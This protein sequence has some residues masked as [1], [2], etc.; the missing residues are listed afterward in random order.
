MMDAVVMAKGILAGTVVSQLLTLYAAPAFAESRTVPVIYAVVLLMLMTVS[1]ASFRLMG[2]FLHRRRDTSHRL[3][4]YGDGDD[5]ALAL[6]EIR[7]EHNQ[8]EI[9][10]FVDDNPE[11]LRTRIHG[12]P[13]LGGFD[14]LL[15][16][17][18]RKAVDA[19]IISRRHVDP[20]KAQQIENLCARQ[21]IAL[22][23]LRVDLRPVITAPANH[24]RVTVMQ[25]KR[26]A[27]DR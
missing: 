6:R 4:I 26:S 5:G 18:E 14:H 1:R 9:V 21:S 16:E 8:Y 27:S 3:I 19:V 11:Q 17:I 15:R 13:V 12:Y 7:Q 2:E 25:P 10:G 20:E 24:P 23:R 22:F